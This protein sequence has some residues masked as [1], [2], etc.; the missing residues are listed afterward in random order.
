M[1]TCHGTEQNANTSIT[2]TTDSMKQ[3]SISLGYLCLACVLGF[4]ASKNLKGVPE[5][6]SFDIAH[7]DA[8]TIAAMICIMLC[9]FLCIG[10]F[11]ALWQSLQ[12]RVLLSANDKG[13]VDATHIHDIQKAT[14]T[15]VVAIQLKSANNNSLML[16]IIVEKPSSN[17]SDVDKSYMVF[18]VS[19]LWIRRSRMQQAFKDLS[20]LAVRMNPEIM[21][22]DD[23]DPL[24][25]AAHKHRMKKTAKQ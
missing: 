13:V 15:E 4:L 3:R 19:G 2:I 1:S 11:K 21:I 6:S 16:D 20:A 10:A 22:L 5:F 14:W 17:P 23:S 8:H 9:V 24:R 12:V 7:I 18:E 25:T